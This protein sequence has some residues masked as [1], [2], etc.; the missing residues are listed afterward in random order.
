MV[1][2][3]FPH[4]PRSLQFNQLISRST[5]EKPSCANCLRQGDKCDY[6]IRLN[7]E[8]RTKRKASEPST[9]KSTSG[10]GSFETKPQPSGLV[11]GPE[12]VSPTDSPLG[13]RDEWS[14]SSN[15]FIDGTGNTWIPSGMTPAVSTQ[16]PTTGPED[17]QTITVQLE[18]PTED[19]VL[20]PSTVHEDF[21]PFTRPYLATDSSSLD[22]TGLGFTALSYGFERNA[23]SQPVS[24][25]R[26][27]SA[28]ALTTEQGGYSSV[29][30]QRHGDHLSPRRYHGQALRDQ[31]AGRL[32]VDLLS[33][34]AFESP[35]RRQPIVTGHEIFYGYDCGVPDYDVPKNN[36][37]E[38]IAPITPSDEVVDDDPISP[39]SEPTPTGS[40]HVR[41]RSS[42]TTG[43]GYYMTPTRV[44]IPRRMLPLPSTLLENPM[45]LLYF[46]HF[47][48]HTARILVPH[49]CD[50]NGMLNILPASESSSV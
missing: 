30:H 11:S 24:F 32:S 44:K 27:T 28:D 37:A 6:S 12:L 48:D 17:H 18:L 29:R 7:W 22:A 40:I 43:G 16:S 20:S 39:V 26:D 49:D 42:F 36:D 5:E 4:R 33:G 31:D 19:T 2:R 15:L 14:A 41:R 45:N 35:D 3:H 1:C 50:R 38:A 10:F 9:P 21:R 46:H 34:G 23:V 13:V 47:I 8:G 25:L